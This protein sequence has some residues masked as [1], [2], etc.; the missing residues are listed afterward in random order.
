M[1]EGVAKG[2][3]SAVI[4]GFHPMVFSEPNP[5]FILS[6]YG[7]FLGLSLSLTKSGIFHPETAGGTEADIRIFV[8]SVVLSVVLVPVAMIV[9]AVEIPAKFVFSILLIGLF[10]LSSDPFYLLVSSMLGLLVLSL[11][12]GV[13]YPL[14]SGLFYLFGSLI[15]TGFK[16]KERGDEIRGAIS[17]FLTGYVPALPPSTW[18]YIVGNANVTTAA[19][20]S[21]VMSLVALLYGDTRSAM[22][23]YIP[24]IDME[25]LPVYIAIF[26][27][28]TTTAY[29]I[30]RAIPEIRKE[31]LLVVLTSHALFMGVSNILLLV[32]ILLLYKLHPPSN[33]ASLF[34]FI[35]APSLLYFSGL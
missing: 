10:V 8:F 26:L 16:F 21:S 23:A 25:V 30:G 5:V 11:P 29:I 20:V 15:L 17:G 35:V 31:V 1:L 2:F 3:I 34:G 6:M 19:V 4:P 22:A 12:T 7:T 14:E 27:F 9:Y 33:P 28:F 32:F 18:S 13:K 24:Y